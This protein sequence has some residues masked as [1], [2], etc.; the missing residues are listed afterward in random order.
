MPFRWRK[1]AVFVSRSAW[2]VLVPG[3]I[4]AP[5]ALVRNFYDCFFVAAPEDRKELLEEARQLRPDDVETIVQEVMTEASQQGAGPRLGADAR[6]I[7]RQLVQALGE[8]SQGAE[9]GESASEALRRSLDQSVLAGAG[10]QLAPRDLS[11][12]QKSIGRLLVS[13][14]LAGGTPGRGRRGD[15]QPPPGISGYEPLRVLGSGGFADVYLMRHQ[16]SGELRAVKVVRMIDDPRRLARELDVLRRVRDEVHL[17]SYRDDGQVD[18]TPWIAMEYVGDTSLAQ[19]L[20]VPAARPTAEQALLLAEQALRGL[21]ALHSRGIIHRDLKPDNIMIDEQFRLRLIDFGLAK[22]IHG[23]GDQSTHIT[24]TAAVVGTPYYMSLEQLR[25]K[26]D[27]APAADLWSFGVVLYQLFLGSVPFH[28]DSFVDVA[29]NISTQQ[30]ELNHD[31]IPVE[32]RSFLGRCLERE[33]SR[34]CPNAGAALEALLPPAQAARRRLRHERYRLTWA[35]LLEHHVLEQF[36]ATEKGRP[37]ADP[38][39]A[40]VRFAA[41]QGAHDL[42]EVRLA[43]VVPAI[44]Q[45]QQKVEAVLAEIGTRKN[46]LQQEMVSLSPSQIH[47]LSSELVELEGQVDQARQQVTRAVH[48]LLKA[49][50]E[51]WD[52]VQRAQAERLAALERERQAA[53]R[54]EAERRADELRRQAKEQEDA[55]RRAAEDQEREAARARERARQRQLRREAA[56]RRWRTA[57]FYLSFPLWGPVAGAFLLGR[58]VLRRWRTI[59]RW[60]GPAFWGAVIGTFIYGGPAWLIRLVGWKQDLFLVLGLVLS[61]SLFVWGLGGTLLAVALAG[62][63]AGEDKKNQTSFGHAC[64]SFLAGDAI[65][66]ITAVAGVF[67]GSLSGA[68]LGLVGGLIAAA[69]SHRQ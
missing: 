39:A 9:R 69:R 21:A 20:K 62:N 31:A 3:V 55:R 24:K 41:A 34:R 8:A 4:A 6:S 54:R 35:P 67:W 68:L 32:V 61:V 36:A 10:K 59:S 14:I 42:D 64:G 40:F 27:L 43:E 17:V 33:A 1:L 60:I 26:G 37:P 13:S 30:V 22:P 66:V 51:A 50:V 15:V 58:A 53:A 7:A 25:G 52:D 63:L 2:D 19:L 48:E 12:E 45:E 49:E 38:V 11:P 23:I 29:L 18:G 65:G 5:L 28:G 44:L 57:L 46:R 16:A 56:S 47:Q